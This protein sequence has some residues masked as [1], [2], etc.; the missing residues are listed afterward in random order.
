[1]HLDYGT[2]T[3]LSVSKLPLKC[4]VVSLYSVKLWLKCNTGKVNSG[5]FQFLSLLFMKTES[6]TLC[7]C[8]ATF[9]THC[10]F[11][12]T[13]LEA[14]PPISK[15]VATNNKTH[16]TCVDDF[17]LLVLTKFYKASVRCCQTGNTALD[18]NQYSNKTD[19]PSLVRTLQK[20]SN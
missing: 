11:Y 12:T 2:Y 4:A 20:N 8:T 9:L 19:Y 5:L 10:I 17:L 13:D 6:N 3:W 1:V 15:H 7:N 14:E 16:T 18:K